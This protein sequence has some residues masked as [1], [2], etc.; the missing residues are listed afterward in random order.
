[1]ASA[2]VLCLVG[3]GWA[4][5]RNALNTSNALDG[6]D[7][8]TGGAMNILLIGLDSRKDQDG[9]QLPPQILDKLHAGDGEEGGYNTNTLILIH[10]PAGGG[11][12]TAFSIPRDDLVSIP[13][14]HPDKIKKAYG[15]AKAKAENALRAQ[16]VT[17]QHQLEMQ[18]RDAGRRATLD[19]VRG[20]TGVPIDHFAEVSLAG[21]Y[22]LANA[23]GGVEVCLNHPVQDAAY[24]GADFPAGRQ[25][26]NGAQALAFVRQRHGLPNGDLDRT[27]RQQAFLASASHEIRSAG[28][29]FDVG[30]TQRLIAAAERDVVTDDGWSAYSLATQL[31][32]MTGGNT[33][34]QRVYL[35]LRGRKTLYDRSRSSGKRTGYG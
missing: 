19:V 26:L 23:L 11:P 13:G 35:C 5:Y 16:G 17:D 6:G 9:R 3:A 27:H 15:Y 28:T 33:D 10:I 20:L 32:N 4:T 8:S 7:R 1:M 12:A 30:R 31:Q 22:D 24:S 29:L 18:S 2:V 14:E 21:F 34:F 25:V